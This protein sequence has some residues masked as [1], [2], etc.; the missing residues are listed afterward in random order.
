M[1]IKKES[2]SLETI[3]LSKSCLLKHVKVLE[4]KMVTT[5][6]EPA[7]LGLLDQCSTN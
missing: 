5:G 4:K 3:F 2:C 6:L 1:S 7:T